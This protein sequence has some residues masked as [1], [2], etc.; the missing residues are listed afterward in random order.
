M[1]KDRGRAHPIRK[2]ACHIHVGVA[3]A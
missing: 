3:E 1:P 2:R